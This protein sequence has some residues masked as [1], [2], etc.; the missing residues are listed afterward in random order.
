[1][2]AARFLVRTML[3]GLLICTLSVPFALGEST[4]VESVYETPPTRKVVYLTFDD[5]P[6]KKTPA[7]LEALKQEG[8]CATFFLI[9]SSIKLYPEYTRDIFDA[10]HSIGSHSFF[11]QKSTLMK[12]TGVDRDIARFDEALSEAV[13][14]PMEV[15][16][17]RFPFGSNW[18]PKEIRHYFSD[19]GF[20]WIDWN[21]SNYDAH[22]EFASDSEKMLEAAIDSS[23]NKDEIVVLMHD[24]K[25]RTIEML[26]KLIQYYRDE[27]FEFDVLTPELEHFIDD[28]HMGLPNVKEIR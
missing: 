12:T 8:V 26:P 16:L 25:G 18:V 2:R 1:M 11:H 24:N 5:G 7:L 3:A 20:L 10:G 22:K 6:S 9:G 21:A 14:Q 19:K 27:G 4:P 23:K 17:F 13:G 28:V 15:R